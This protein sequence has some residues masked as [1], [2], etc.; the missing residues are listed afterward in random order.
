MGPLCK[1]HL[2]PRLRT[3]PWSRV[4]AKIIFEKRCLVHVF[5]PSTEA[6]MD[7]CEFEASLVYIHE[8]RASYPLAGRPLPVVS[9]DNFNPVC[10]TTVTLTQFPSLRASGCRDC[11]INVSRYFSSSCIAHT[12]AT[13][14]KSKQCKGCIECH[15]LPDREP[16]LLH[17]HGA[18]TLRGN[19]D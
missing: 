6:E 14:R 2:I 5:N 8:H 9:S 16:W 4:M 15:W 17:L 3:A 1:G 10:Q 18:Q 13:R 19:L 7:R 11:K 12:E